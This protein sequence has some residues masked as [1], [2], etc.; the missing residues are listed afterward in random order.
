[1]AVPID[2]RLQW[3]ACYDSTICRVAEPRLE[4]VL[5]FVRV[6]KASTS[7]KNKQTPVNQDAAF[8]AYGQPYCSFR[9]QALT[10]PEKNSYIMLPIWPA[11][12]SRPRLRMTWHRW[13]FSNAKVP[14]VLLPASVMY[15]FLN[16][17]PFNTMPR[18]FNACQGP[19]GCT[20]IGFDESSASPTFFVTK[21]A[22][23]SGGSSSLAPAKQ[24]NKQQRSTTSVCSDLLLSS[25]L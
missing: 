8:M 14:D 16:S 22:G 10:S 3:L 15:F 9:R 13:T 25:R 23:S 6:L 19:I 5:E 7:K 12:P 20:D 11:P 4:S 17:Q 24:C 2:C 21:T 18:S 1:M